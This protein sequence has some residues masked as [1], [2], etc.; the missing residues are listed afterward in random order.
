MGGRVV[1]KAGV[2]RVVWERPRAKCPI[3]GETQVDHIPFLAVARSLGTYC[4]NLPFHLTVTLWLLSTQATVACI[5]YSPLQGSDSF[6]VH[7]LCACV[8]WCLLLLLAIARSSCLNQEIGTWAQA[9]DLVGKTIA[10]QKDKIPTVTGDLWS[11]NSNNGEYAISPEPDVHSRKFNPT[12]MR[13][14]VLASDGL[15]NIIDPKSAITI[16]E[17]TERKGFR[18]VIYGKVCDRYLAI[19]MRKSNTKWV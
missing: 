18:E 7:G 19:I 2:P 9:Y 17:M 13:C 14:L 11:Y 6:H 3:R 12:T 16:T 8:I 10:M 1:P 15:W 4:R 5:N